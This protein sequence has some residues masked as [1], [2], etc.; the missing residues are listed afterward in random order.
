MIVATPPHLPGIFGSLAPVLNSYGYLAVAG[1]VL[2]ESFGL[3]LPGETVLIAAAI[4]AGAGQ[5]NIVAVATVAWAAAVAGNTIGFAL[6]RQGGRRL[7]V[8][9]GRYV[10]L[11]PERIDRA[12]DFLARRGVLVVVVGRFVEGLR[13]LNG[14]IAGISDM[15]WLRF[16]LANAVGAALWVG[17]WTA[18]GDVAGA[19]IDPVYRAVQRYTVY[20]LVAAGVIIVGFVVRHI[21]RRR[22]RPAR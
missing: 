6:G 15:S 9:W 12:S 19:H 4:Y 13:Q 2:A 21:R 18:V 7:L 3:P 5:L 17:A 1:L 11:T 8:R 22:G 14:I 16:L 10:R 20:A